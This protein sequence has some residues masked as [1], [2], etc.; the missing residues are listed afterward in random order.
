MERKDIF[1]EIE[2]ILKRTI[3][4]NESVK[5]ETHLAYDLGF[6]SMDT[7][8]T[9]IDIELKFRI[10]LQDY[11]HEQVSTVSSLI[12]IVEKKL[13][14]KENRKLWFPIFFWIQIIIFN[15]SLFS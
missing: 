10:V 9:I 3:S 4:N 8:C 7:L 2:K 6:D 11:E 5:E 13:L 14:A 1:K 15:L 12:D